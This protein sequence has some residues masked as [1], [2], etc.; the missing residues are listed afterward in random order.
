MILCLS[1]LEFIMFRFGLNG[2]VL[3]FYGGFFLSLSKS[4]TV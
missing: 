3:E 4:R 2:A 1:I